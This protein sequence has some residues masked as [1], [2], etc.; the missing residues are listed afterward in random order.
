MIA[1][2][3]TDGQLNLKDLHKECISEKWIPL[4]TLKNKKNETILPIFNLSDIARQFI[5]RNLPKNWQHGCV[6]LAEDD[7]K[8]IIKKNWQFMA[9]DFPRKLDGHPEF[10]FSFEIHEFA[11]QPDFQY[12]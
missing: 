12:K 9:L 7:I 8:N 3:C 1:I 10:E 11:D 2:I 6:F 5:K 4:L